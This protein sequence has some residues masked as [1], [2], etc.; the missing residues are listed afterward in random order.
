MTTASLDSFKISQAEP[1]AWC[2]LKDQETQPSEPPDATKCHQD[3]TPPNQGQKSVT[4]DM[5]V[6]GLMHHHSSVIQVPTHPAEAQSH[7]LT[8]VLAPTHL[9]LPP[10]KYVILVQQESI[11][12]PPKLP[13]VF[14]LILD[15]I[16]WGQQHK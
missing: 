4:R 11:K 6:L 5:L 16:E 8:A 14:L 7:A 1:S 9:L 12:K 2:V 15:T 3:F 10:P 13:L